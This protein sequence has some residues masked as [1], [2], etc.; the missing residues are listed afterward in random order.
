VANEGVYPDAMTICEEPQLWNNHVDVIVNPTL[1]VEVLSRPTQKHDRG[2][3][4]DSYRTIPS[5][6]HILVISQDRMFVEHYARQS[7][8]HW[9]ITEYSEREDSIGLL[10]AVLKV[11]E[12]YDGL[13]H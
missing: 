3:K 2:T 9:H 5:L 13:L 7:K 4:A 11:E 12:F 10:G 1:V 6:R 8:K